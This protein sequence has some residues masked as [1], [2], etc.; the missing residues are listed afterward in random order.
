MSGADKAFD[1]YLAQAAK[2]GD[3]RALA[4]LY[5]RW[6][7]RLIAHAWRLTGDQDAAREAAQDAWADIV[8]GLRALHDAAAFPA[9][10][11]RIV[12]RRCANRVR[13]LQAERAL[14]SQ[15]AIQ[16]AEPDHPADETTR[17]RQAVAALPPD[18]RAAVAL[19]YFDELSVAETAVALDVPVGTVKTRLMH[20]RRK[21]RHILEGDDTCATSTK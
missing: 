20:A 5:A 7:K 1:A 3:A 17:L 13:A 10:A 16:A 2:S 6:N 19:F 14:A 4:A 18:Q 9:W 15:L 12:S 11:Y 21:L 8:R